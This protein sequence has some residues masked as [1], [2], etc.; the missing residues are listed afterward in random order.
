VLPRREILVIDDDPDI[1]EGLAEALKSE[2]YA[3]RTAVDGYDALRQL[4]SRTADVILLDLMMPRMDGW[5]FRVA[6]KRE[7]AG[8]ASI[9][10][11]VV[12]ASGAEFTD[13]NAV[14]RKPFD[15]FDLLR[16]VKRCVLE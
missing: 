12:T 10:V 4:R 11:I 9:P 8:I 7:Q 13:A 1:R 3:V 6:Q 14:L 15:I 5:Q 2:G 16:V